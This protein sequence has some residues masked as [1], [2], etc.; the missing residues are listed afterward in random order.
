M[1]FVIQRSILVISQSANFEPPC[2]IFENPDVCF[3][4]PRKAAFDD[5]M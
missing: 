4:D 1:P 3:I 2:G 5:V